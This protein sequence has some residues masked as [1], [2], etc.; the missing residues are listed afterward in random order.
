MHKKYDPIYKFLPLNKKM[1]TK[2][3]PSFDILH[4]EKSRCKA[5]KYS[6]MITDSDD[7]VHF[8]HFGNPKYEHFYDR[9]PLKAFSHLNHKDRDRRILFHKD[10]SMLMALPLNCQNTIFGKIF[11]F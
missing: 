1:I 10:S 9:T 3:F 7:K 11:Y 6:A 4:M 8:V 5:N 2:K